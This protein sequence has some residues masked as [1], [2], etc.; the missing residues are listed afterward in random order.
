MFFVPVFVVINTT[1]L[2][3]LVPYIA[4][5]AASLS[6][7]MDSMSE[8]LRKSTASNHTPSTTYKGSELLG[9]PTPL[10]L[11]DSALPGDPELCVICTPE[12]RPC[13]ACSRRAAG[14]LS[15]S[16]AVVT[17]TAPVMALLFWVP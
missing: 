8:G 3:P 12:T 5:E 1:P 11:T 17:D 10:I 15:I 13:K 16:S 6:T 9:V 7:D 14:N 2:A 4:A